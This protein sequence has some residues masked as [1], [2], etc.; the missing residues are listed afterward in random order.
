[1]FIL[2]L[3]LCKYIKF[4]ILLV[5][6]FLVDFCHR[7]GHYRCTLL[8]SSGCSRL[9]GN[10]RA[11]WIDKIILDA[12]RFKWLAWTCINKMNGWIQTE[13]SLFRFFFFL[14]FEILFMLVFS[15]CCNNYICLTVFFFFFLSFIII[16]RFSFLFGF[17]QFLRNRNQFKQ[18]PKKKRKKKP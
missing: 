17:T 13:I 1:M 14:S 2:L 11:L 10:W 12:L 3:L 8:L 15:A 6:G 7:F 4:R 5:F 16:I 9:L 18:K